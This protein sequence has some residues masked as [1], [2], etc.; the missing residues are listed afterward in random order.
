[1][2]SHEPGD[3]SDPTNQDA[4]SGHRTGAAGRARVAVF[5][6]SHWHAPLYRDALLRRH[7]VVAVQDGVP[8]A[9]AS[10]GSWGLQ[11][12]SDVD[13]VLNGTEIDAAYVMS[14]HDEVAG[15]C[16]RL[17]ERRIPFVVEKP[18]G[19]GLAELREVA[20]AA[21]VAG[22]AATVALVQRDGPVEAWLEQ[23][24]TMS[25]ERFSFHAGPPSRYLANGSPWM[26]DPVRAGGGALVNL[27][28]HFVDLALRHLGPSVVTALTRS[29]ALHG[30]QVE[31][32][33]TVLL[34]GVRG[35]QALV[36]VGYVFPDSPLKRYCSF[37][38]A[39]DLGFASIDTDGTAHFTGLDG[40]T[41]SATVNVDSDPLYEVL[42]D[43]V[44]DT[45][46]T[47]FEGMP[48][49]ADLAAAMQV[50]WSDQS[51]TEDHDA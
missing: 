15:V 46:A 37:S 51:E 17:I 20:E 39:G 42:V 48:T 35:G 7:E 13:L 29:H 8:H 24:G 33:A 6:A 18:L 14:P 32:H 44:A 2:T 47:G 19:L 10:P 16:L 41:A 30:G 45:L 21:R 50:I 31:D 36:E 4:P 43:R 3:P 49:L 25:Y 34:T 11:V 22:V 1:M 26:L 27:G 23:V 9:V 40:R 5:G 38:A 12:S 28:P